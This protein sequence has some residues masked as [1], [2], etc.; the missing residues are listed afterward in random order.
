MIACP[1]ARN[2]PWYGTSPKGT[3]TQVPFIPGLGPAARSRLLLR[4]ETVGGAALR[5]VPATRLP[6]GEIAALACCQGFF[7]SRIE[8]TP[9]LL[10]RILWL[11]TSVFTAAGSVIGVVASLKIRRARFLLREG[12]TARGW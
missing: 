4:E 9:C 11:F 3:R 12:S 2:P 10:P 6:Q 1:E 7:G 8:T 5:A